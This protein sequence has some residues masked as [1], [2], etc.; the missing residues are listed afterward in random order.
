MIKKNSVFIGMSFLLLSTTSISCSS[1]SPNTPVSPASLSSGKVIDIGKGHRGANISFKI[2]IAAKNNFRVKDSS[3]G[4]PAHSSG[5]IDHFVVYLITDSNSGGFNSTGDPVGSASGFNIASGTTTIT[6]SNV[7]GSG[8]NYYYVSARAVDEG[9]NDLLEKNANWS[10]TA[11]STY[12]GRVA[13]SS[14]SGV[15]V[16]SDYQITA[17]PTTDLPVDLN[18]EDAV[19]A[20]IGS[21]LNVNEG[22]TDIGSIVV[23]PSPGT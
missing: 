6:F 21:S 2:N 23:S 18:L 14:G 3:S 17:G 19:G 4:N 16:D 9:G 20:T 15:Q 13:V 22:N 5:Q 12:A 7:P 1:G 8:G 11:Q 10:G